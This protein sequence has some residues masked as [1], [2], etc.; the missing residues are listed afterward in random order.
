MVGLLYSIDNN[1]TKLEVGGTALSVY[2]ISD[3]SGD[4]LGKIFTSVITAIYVE[5]GE[6]SAVLDK[7]SINS[8]GAEVNGKIFYS[9]VKELT[10]LFKKITKKHAL[11]NFNYF[12]PTLNN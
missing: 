8:E 12:T 10:M 4:E 2:N 11:C 3:L 6:Q 7:V 9:R 5:L 1:K